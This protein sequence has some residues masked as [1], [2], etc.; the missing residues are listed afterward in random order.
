MI[1][2]VREE[3]WKLVIDTMFLGTWLFDIGVP[4]LPIDCSASERITI[5]L[6]YRIKA[7]RPRY[8]IQNTHHVI[9]ITD[10]IIDY[11]IMNYASDEFI[12]EWNIRGWCDINVLAV[13]SDHSRIVRWL[14]GSKQYY[15]VQTIWKL[16][17]SLS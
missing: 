7:D 4:E 10:R 15:E 1:V 11:I 16:I 17:Q 2:S 9:P 13:D 14:S 5:Y 6:N 3:K 12:M 8:N